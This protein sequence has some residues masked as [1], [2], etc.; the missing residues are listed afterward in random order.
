MYFGK[1]S[2]SPLMAAHVASNPITQI[3]PRLSM[4]FRTKRLGK[5]IRA[6]KTA[7]NVQ[8]RSWWYK[9]SEKFPG[10]GKGL[11]SNFQE[12]SLFPKGKGSACRSEKIHHLWR[13]FEIPP[14]SSLNIKH[15]SPDPLNRS[16]VILDHQMSLVLSPPVP[17]SFGN[18][19]SM[20]LDRCEA[21][22]HSWH[23]GTLP[24]KCFFKRA[25]CDGIVPIILQKQVETTEMLR[26]GISYRY[27]I[28]LEIIGAVFTKPCGFLVPFY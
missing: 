8:N 12:T 28:F 22:K 15:G 27:I 19:P 2:L 4:K 18:S 3:S 1:S 10:T 23:L 21:Q 11:P 7:S 14:T 26:R 13:I 5:V 16:S 20:V 6:K 24:G 17:S 25:G 9:N